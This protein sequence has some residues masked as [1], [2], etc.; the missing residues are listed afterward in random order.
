MTLDRYIRQPGIEMTLMVN[1]LSGDAVVLWDGGV[2]VGLSGFSRLE[3]AYCKAEKCEDKESGVGSYDE[4]VVEGN[5]GVLSEC[6]GGPLELEVGDNVVEDFG[7]FVSFLG[8]LSECGIICEAE[9]NHQETNNDGGYL[10]ESCTAGNGECCNDEECHEDHE[11]CDWYLS[12]GELAIGSKL[13]EDGLEF[14]VLV[15]H[16][17]EYE[18]DGECD[19]EEG[20][21]FGS[22]DPVVH[23]VTPDSD[24]ECDC[25]GAESEE[26]N[27][28]V[29][30]IRSGGHDTMSNGEEEDGHPDPVSEC[31]G[32]GDADVF[33]KD[34]GGASD[35][36]GDN[37]ENGFVFNFLGDDAGCREGSKEET[38]KEHGGE[39]EVDEKFVVVVERVAG[40]QWVNADQENGSK[41][42]DH[43]DRLPN[44][45]GEGVTRDSEYLLKHGWGNDSGLCGKGTVPVHCTQTCGEGLS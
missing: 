15:D 30:F 34:E 23:V 17:D 28:E 36:F 9:E 22:E 8:S 37:R 10:S 6:I 29:V 27:G 33:A 4:Q 3:E 41:Q 14:P 39:V 32:A 1:I 45:F 13:K 2:V 35:G 31:H 38:C 43:E 11:C 40:E 21:E 20:I 25:D 7:D 18:C 26:V 44:G 5:W 19:G 24:G 42:N 16:H 12:A